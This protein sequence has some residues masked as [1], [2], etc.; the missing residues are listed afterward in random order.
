MKRAAAAALACSLSTGCIEYLDS[1][2]L[3]IMRYMGDYPGGVDFR[4]APPTADR[5]GN[6]YVLS[7]SQELAQPQASVGYFGGG[8]WRAQCDV[9]E[10]T[11]R[12]THGWVGVAFDRAWYWSG[13]SLVEIS[14]VHSNCRQILKRDPTSRADLAF[15]GVVPWVKLTPSRTTMV[16]MVQAPSDPVP[17]YVVVDLDLRRYAKFE[18]FVPRNG[19]EVDVLGVGA[20]PANDAGFMVV[21]YTIDEEVRAEARFIDDDANVTDIVNV[22]GLGAAAEDAFI[23]YMEVGARGWVGGV[24]VPVPPEMPDEEPARAI[25]LFN[26]EE[27]KLFDELGSFQPEGVHRWGDKAYVVGVAN[28]RPAISEISAGG[29]EDPEVWTTSERIARSLQSTIL[30]QD[31]RFTPVQTF[32]WTNP[33]PAFGAFPMLHPNSPSSYAIDTSLITISGPEYT[34]GGEVFTSLAVGPVGLAYP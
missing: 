22:P 30:I 33:S 16:A 29:L 4:F 15:K 24:V 18:E 21:R 26:R 14:G 34:S 10:G 19:S 8:G 31:D 20:D 13:D 7:G 5:N 25:L 28:G 2:E 9:H 6:L 1:G 17:F 12:G 11:D 23:G 3:G 27:A 32:D